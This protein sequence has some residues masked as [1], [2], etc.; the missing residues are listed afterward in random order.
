MSVR[1]DHAVVIGGSIGGCP[2]AMV[3]SEF[4]DR[5]TVLDR[6]ELP[7][8]AEHHRGV[9]QSPHLHGLLYGGRLTLDEL[10]DDGFTAAMR[11]AGGPYFDFAK[12][13]AFRFPEG[14]IKRAPGNL[15]VIFSTRWTME[16]VIRELTRREATISFAVGQ[17]AGF[18]TTADGQRVTGI[19]LKDGGQIEADLVVDA[20]GRGSKSPAWMEEI[21]FAAPQESWVRSFLGYSTVY[22]FVPEEAWPGDIKSIAAPPFPGTTRGGFVVPQE[23]GLV[24]IMAAGQTRDYPPADEQGLREFLRTAITPVLFEMYEQLEPETEIRTTKTSHNRLV[25]WHELQRR[26]QGFL[27]IG[28]AVAAF[29]PVYGQGIT[30]AALQAKALRQALNDND[31]LETVVAGF[32]ARAM[33]VCQFAWTGATDADCA[34]EGTEVANLERTESDAEITAYL[35]KLRLATTLDSLV[36]QAFFRAQGSMQGALLFEPDLMERVER[37]CGEWDD[38]PRDLLRPPEWAEDAPPVAA[39]IEGGE[40]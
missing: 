36:A 18:T 31:E 8:H 24:G 27:A 28:D 17:A 2:A 34:F 12:H 39:Y 20:A 13:Q 5:V 4:F 22:G 14:W 37:V 23:N 11:E 3:L 38:E 26:P 15:M 29:N 9:P 35:S 10:F 6:D 16:H 19:K 40:E 7:L 1:G 32:P 21:G 25:R 30:T 33:E